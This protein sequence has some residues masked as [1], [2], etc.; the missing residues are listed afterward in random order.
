MHLR[1]YT[2]IRDSS[3]H[4]PVAITAIKPTPPLI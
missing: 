1:P 3:G 4:Q 2:K